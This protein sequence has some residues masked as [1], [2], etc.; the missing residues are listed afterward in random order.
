M[1]TLRN[2]SSDKGLKLFV[3]KYAKLFFSI[4]R[5]V[6]N[7]VAL[8]FKI[9]LCVLCV[10][11]VQSSTYAQEPTPV[12]VTDDQ[13]NAIAAR[14]Y[15]PSCQGVPLDDCGTQVCAE[16][17][18]EIRA[19]LRAGRTEEEII[20]GFVQRYGER[21]IGTPQD[22]L[23]RAFSLVTPYLIGVL[24]IL[25]ALWTILRWRHRPALVEGIPITAEPAKSDDDYRARLEQDL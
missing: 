6:P 20:A 15:C 10:S 3:Q 11:A 1:R 9:L 17:R 18:E 19:Q 5:V 21:I 2:V 8:W 14:M 22:P 23:L 16:W 13:V 12:P 25:I 24:V 4:P 7:A